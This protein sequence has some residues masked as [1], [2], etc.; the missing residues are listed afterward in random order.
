ML[1]VFVPV[2][3][4]ALHNIDEPSAV[5]L[6]SGPLH[7]CRYLPTVQDFEVWLTD[8]MINYTTSD[9]F[10]R[11]FKIWRDNVLAVVK[12][13]VEAL[14]GIHTYTL[15]LNRL[16]DLSLAEFS[17]AF[18]TTARVP[19]RGS[20]LELSTSGALDH[21]G[22]KKP[23]RAWDWRNQ[24]VITPVKDQGQ[25]G[26][27]WAFAAVG[28][29][30][31]AYNHHYMHSSNG[32][33]S[34]CHERCGPNHTAC[35]SFSEQEIIDCTRSGRYTCDTGGEIE[36]AFYELAAVRHGRIATE[37]V[38]PYSSGHTL[39]LNKC[40]VSETQAKSNAVDTGVKGYVRVKAGSETALRDA[41][42]HNPGVAVAVDAHSLAFQLY[43]SGVLDL[44]PE[45][46]SSKKLNHGVLVTGYGGGELAFS[47]PVAGLRVKSS[48][49]YWVVKNSWGT[50]G[51][52]GYV[53]MS[54]NA[55]NQ[56]GIASE[57]TFPIIR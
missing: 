30:E 18:L 9:L 26:S 23:P 32:L 19:V 57:A 17:S 1:C 25:C 36:D 22:S 34:A 14:N 56:C 6:E 40:P 51:M 15:G 10:D 29:V 11:R 52:N 44:G 47:G 27:C 53:Y 7:L 54:R 43:Y 16:A 48:G 38:Y 41:A 50:W 45:E 49:E 20:P 39:A 12:H 28:A 24:G 13:N 2:I 4:M 42:Y 21:T 55:E 35:C 3:A 33:S 46:C 8:H 37:D 5:T 31:G